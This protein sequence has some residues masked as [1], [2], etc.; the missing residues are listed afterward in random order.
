MGG[1]LNPSLTSLSCHTVQTLALVSPWGWG[2]DGGPTFPTSRRPWVSKG[3]SS[4]RS[5]RNAQAPSQTE[6]TR[7]TPARGTMT[8]V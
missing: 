4:A 2:L 8:F 3:N 7:K 1:M 5:P 6:P